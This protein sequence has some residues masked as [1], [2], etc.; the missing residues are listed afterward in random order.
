MKKLISFKMI[1]T[2]GLLLAIVLPARVSAQ[3]IAV[4]NNQEISTPLN[5]NNSHGVIYL[6]TREVKKQ[7]NQISSFKVQPDKAPIILDSSGNFDQ[8]IIT[9]N[10]KK[11][12]KILINSVKYA[13]LDHMPIVTPN[14]SLY[15]M[16][17]LSGMALDHPNPK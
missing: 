14:M 9:L 17:V 13:A 3:H 2:A 11:T 5:L 8:R 10:G 12:V 15:R 4:L 6:T 1:I 7:G 16:P